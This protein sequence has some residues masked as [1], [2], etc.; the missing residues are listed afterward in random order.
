V[1][2]LGREVPVV[3]FVVLAVSMIIV[4]IVAG[5]LLIKQ[6]SSILENN[7]LALE[8]A[9]QEHGA[10][11]DE[12]VV[13]EEQIVQ[14]QIVQQP[15]EVPHGSFDSTVS[16]LLSCSVL[17]VFIW[18]FVAKR[19]TSAKKTL[20]SI[21]THKEKET[22]I[23]ESNL[24]LQ[25]STADPNTVL[26]MFSGGR[27]SLLATCRLLDA[28]HSVLLVTYDNGCTLYSDHAKTTANCLIEK[29]GE[30]KVSFL[31]Y[32]IAGVWKEF[33]LPFFNLKSSEILKKYG[34]I[35]YSQ[36]NCLSCRTSMY[37]YS[38]ALCKVLGFHT[39]SDGARHSQGFAVEL[40][41]VLSRFKDLV[42]SYGIELVSPVL[43]LDSDWER[44]NELLRKELPTKVLEPQC[45]VGVPLSPDGTLDESVVSAVCS[46]FDQE[47]LPRF[48]G[49]V[50]EVEKEIASSVNS[51]L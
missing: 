12:E 49:L 18:R 6:A 14:E 32:S 11:L 31:T 27:D 24:L 33:L 29:Y 8:E 37:V 51:I 45:L 42:N 4:V 10:T 16:F 36:F 17:F 3:F 38:I 22:K 5:F 26:Q 44:K 46:F 47:I 40:D 23:K 1:V 41:P 25:E 48:S 35:T 21:A 28:G 9:L 20:V 7:Q 15:E 19:V 2:F 30:S 50:E 39:I 43:T 13:A 34:E